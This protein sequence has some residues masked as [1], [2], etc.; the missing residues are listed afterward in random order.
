MAQSKA[1]LRLLTLNT[2]SWQEADNASCLRYVAEAVLAERPDVIALQEV[3]QSENGA[4]ADPGRLRESGFVSCG[5]DIVENNWA[6]LLAEKLR[7]AGEDWYWSWGFAHIGYRSWAEGVALLSRAP[8]TQVRSIDISDPGLPADSWRHRRVLAG[9]NEYG[10]FCSVHAGWWG[11]EADPFR[12]QWKRLIGF[13]Q[14]LDGPRYLM[15]DFNCPAHLPN[16]GYAL[17]LASG[18]QDCYARAADKDAGITV[19]GQIDGWRDGRVEGLRLDLCLAGQPGRT[20]R[21]RV[22]FNGAFYPV[23]SDHFGVFTWEDNAESSDQ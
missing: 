13:A 14:G 22:I 15:G 6:L 4:P 20:L 1:D 11:D 17:M 9:R 21:S 16:E 2:H 7:N 5:F 23:I 8:L 3:N 10:W 12:N 18:M 19:P